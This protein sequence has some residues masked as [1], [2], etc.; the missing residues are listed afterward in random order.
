MEQTDGSMKR[1]SRAAV[2]RHRSGSPTCCASG[3]PPGPDHRGRGRLSTR[4]SETRQDVECPAISED[5]RQSTPVSLD[6]RE[7]DK[8]TTGTRHARLR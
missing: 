8:M 4:R 7:S 5:R 1:S 6:Q 2:T 3:S